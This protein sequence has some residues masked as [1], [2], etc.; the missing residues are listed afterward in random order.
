MIQK[1]ETWNLGGVFWYAGATRSAI[2][3]RSAARPGCSSNNHTAK[4]SFNAFKQITAT[5]LPGG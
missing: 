1:R 5:G 2:S 3:A 4:P